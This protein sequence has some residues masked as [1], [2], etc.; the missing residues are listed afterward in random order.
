MMGG[1]KL[2]FSERQDQQADSYG[3]LYF[4][5]PLLLLL[6]LCCSKLF[7]QTGGIAQSRKVTSNQVIAHFGT[8]PP[9]FREPEIDSS[10]TA[11]PTFNTDVSGRC[12]KKLLRCLLFLLFITPDQAHGNKKVISI[13]K[14]RD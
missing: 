11:N 8:K 6:R 2:E 10:T 9:T 5:L 7:H 1:D 3:V 14:T 4:V 13:A 12:Y